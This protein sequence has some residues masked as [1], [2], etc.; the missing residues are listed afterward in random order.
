MSAVNLRDERAFYG[1][2]WSVAGN[3]YKRWC[4]K[5]RQEMQIKDNLIF[6]LEVEEE[7]EDEELLAHLRRELAL[8]SKKYREA[9]VLYYVKNK[10]CE[11]IS[12]ILT[13]SI[14]M[15]KYLLFKTR[16]I[17]KVGMSMERHFGEQSYYPRELDLQ[18]WGC[19]SGQ[20]AEVC[21]GKIAQNI[22]FAC[23]QDKLTAE[24]I[25]LQIGVM[26][27]YMEEELDQLLNCGL[28]IRDGRKYTA[29]IV[30]FTTE[31]VQEIRNQTNTSIG[32]IAE[33]IAK[34]IEENAMKVRRIAGYNYSMRIETISWQ[35]TCMILYHAV[36]TRLI[37]THQFT[38]SANRIRERCLIW[39]V[40]RE[41]NASYAVGIS[42]RQNSRGDYIQ[43]MDFPA[44]GEMLHRYCYSRRSAANLLLDIAC[45][46]TDGFSENDWEEVAEM[47]NRGYVISDREHVFVNMPVFTQMQYDQ[48][49]QSIDNTIQC[50]EREMRGIVEEIS[51]ILKNQIPLH[52]RNSANDLAYLRLLEDGISAEIEYLLRNKVLVPYCQGEMLPTTHIVLK[53]N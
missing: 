40:E 8:L 52:L 17:V 50:I 53:N 23:Y 15:V 31:L 28:L 21:N 12:E 11:E 7:K 9:A 14:S 20:Y 33:I 27:P 38:L 46:R 16:Q 18:F 43:F 32:K 48:I 36:V 22:L 29:N 4:R 19:D 41:G 24:Q 5:K 51:Q 13:I 39:A 1:F 30:V 37:N 49:L 3:V 44:H 25:S 6:S 45:G 26:L 47:M 34:G 10:S 35:V 42:N 2:M